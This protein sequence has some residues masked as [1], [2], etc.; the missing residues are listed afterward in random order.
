MIFVVNNQDFSRQ[1]QVDGYT[2]TIRKVN[3][4]AAGV[5][6]NGEQVADQIAV[7]KDLSIQVEAGDTATISSLASLCSEEY[8]N[9]IFADPVSGDSYVG[10]YMPQAQGIPMAIDQDHKGMTYWYGFTINFREK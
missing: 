7:K 3:G 5:L 8:V 1:V 10:V 4:P 2:V 9:L 6:L